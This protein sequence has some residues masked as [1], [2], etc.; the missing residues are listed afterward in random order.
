M[1]GVLDTTLCDKAYK[2]LA[3]A[4]WFSLGTQVSSTNKSDR[5]DITEILLE[6]SLNT[7]NQTKPNHTI[8][9]WLY[10]VDKCVFLI[11]T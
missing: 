7:M 11:K 9:T 10:I 8:S 6:V 5:H 4:W 2:W 1:A 3:T